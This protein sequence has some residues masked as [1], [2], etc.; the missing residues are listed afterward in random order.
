VL[1]IPADLFI[2]TNKL[3]G[4]RETEVTEETVIALKSPLESTFDI[5]L[6]E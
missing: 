6:T 1:C 2:Q 3:G 5:T 4:S